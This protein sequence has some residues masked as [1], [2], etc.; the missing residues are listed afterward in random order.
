MLSRP[1]TFNSNETY[2]MRLFPPYRR[3]SFF[4]SVQNQ[5][6]VDAIKEAERQ[7]SGEIRVYIESRCRFVDPIDRAAEIF[8]SLRMDQTDDR[9]AVLLYVAVKDHQFAI[10][11]DKGIYEKLGPEFWH[12]EIDEMS[13]HFGEHRYTEALLYVIRDAGEA[14]QQHF[15]YNA[16]ADRNELPDDIIFGR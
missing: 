8:W 15:P 2:I 13:R 10:F 3:R 11:A 5:C 4:T 14:L 9:N 16:H 6:I 12:R 1:R 7:T